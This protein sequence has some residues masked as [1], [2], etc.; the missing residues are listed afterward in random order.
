MMPRSFGRHEVASERLRKRIGGQDRQRVDPF[1]ACRRG[2]IAS[3]GGGEYRQIHMDLPICRYSGVEREA[4]LD[5]GTSMDFR[6]PTIYPGDGVGFL[7]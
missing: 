7:E 4:Q 2:G 5:F 6:T 1:S 3:S